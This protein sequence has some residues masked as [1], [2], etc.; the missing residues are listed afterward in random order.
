[1]D[2]LWQ[3]FLRRFDLERTFRF[4]EQTPGWTKPRIRTPGA[5]LID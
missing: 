1:M 2:R 3:I 4:L 5:R